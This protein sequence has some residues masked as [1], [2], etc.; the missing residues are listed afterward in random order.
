VTV[1]SKPLWDRAPVRAERP[2]LRGVSWIYDSHPESEAR[3]SGGRASHTRSM[4]LPPAATVMAPHGSRHQTRVT[5]RA[6]RANIADEDEEEIRDEPPALNLS[7]Q[8]VDGEHVG[9]SR[10]S[11]RYGPRRRQRVAP[12]EGLRRF[13]LSRIEGV[14]FGAAPRGVPPPPGP[15]IWRLSRRTSVDRG[16]L[17]SPKSTSLRPHVAPGVAP[18]AILNLFVCAPETRKPCD[19]QGFRGI[20]GAGFEP[21]TFGL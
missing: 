11:S 12:A 13:R 9:H 14:F 16:A 18:W 7:P 10:P 1:R 4:T 8:A 15:F 2:S 20:A 17:T 6:C 5:S 19:L 21:A 3:L